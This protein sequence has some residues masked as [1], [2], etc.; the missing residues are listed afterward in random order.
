[1]KNR[2]VITT[3]LFVVILTGL[4]TVLSFFVETSFLPVVNYV[5]FYWI[6][7]VANENL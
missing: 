6:I 4:L 5:F 7:F 1:M 3:G 2:R